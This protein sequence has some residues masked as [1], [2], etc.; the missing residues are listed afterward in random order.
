MRRV[1]HDDEDNEH[2]NQERRAIRYLI[3]LGRSAIADIEPPSRWDEFVHWAKKISEHESFRPRERDYKLEYAQQIIGA[4]NK[5]RNNDEDWFTDLRRA[6]TGGA[7]PV[8]YMV[9]DNFR[10]WCQSNPVRADEALNIIWNEER[11]PHE[12]LHDFLEIVPRDVLK[13]P[14]ARLSMAS[15]LLSARDPTMYPVYRAM[16]VDKSMELLRYPSFEWEA[17]DADKY[18]YVLNFLDQLGSEFQERTGIEV[19]RLGAQGLAWATSMWGYDEAPI[20]E[21]PEEER[22]AFRRF[23][24]GDKA[25]A[26]TATKADPLAELADELLIDLKHLV[27]IRDLL[28]SKGQVIFY[29]PPG[30]GKTYLARKLAHVLAQPP[31]GSED[32]D[33]AGM[34]QVVQ[35]HPSYAYEDFVEGFRPRKGSDGDS[36]FDLVDGPLKDI[37]RAALSAP[38]TKHILIIDEINRGNV[39][40]VLGELYFLLEYRDEKIRLQ[41]SDEEFGLPKNLWVIGTMNT[42]DRSIALIDAALRRRFY[43]VPFFPDEPPIEGL[44]R[45][46]LERHQSDYV[47]VA[48]VVDE[49]NRRL[50]DKHTA[51]GP[52]YFM[53]PNL[54]DGWIERIWKHAV[55][56]YI[57]EQFFGEPERLAEFQLHE[58][59]RAGQPESVIDE[60]DDAPADAS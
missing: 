45:R 50:G 59:R 14:S 48:E 31:D 22:E 9:T 11:D 51:I 49:A 33:E 16:W 30:T 37:A 19:D 42:A 60:D 7:H 38:E 17:P 54:N 24:E 56:P 40:K 3:D 44:L 55:L 2:I 18:D 12:C 25:Q 52:S 43:F 5:F 26:V 58:L 10:K 53:R 1:P 39:A 57:E 36:Y 34:V 6:M 20:S 41:Y 35:F 4:R 28:E 23:R 13:G 46:W 21:W 15:F 32:E 8:H 47:W 29:G 27:E